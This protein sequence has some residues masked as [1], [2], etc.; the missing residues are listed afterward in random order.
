MKKYAGVEASEDTNTDRKRA[1]KT[2]KRELGSRYEKQA[3]AFLEQKGLRILE[4]N[5]YCRSGEIDLIAREGRYLVFVEVKYRHTQESGWACAAVDRRKQRAISRT[6]QFYLVRYGYGMD[7]PCRFDVV[8][9]DGGKL[10]WIRNAFDY[11]G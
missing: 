4:R 7:T 8:A 11:C 9:I 6:A 3:A 2:N 1:G 5:F 10:Q